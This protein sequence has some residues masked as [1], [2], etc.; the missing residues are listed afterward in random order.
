[1]L[2][3]FTR[4]TDRLVL[5][6]LPEII[7]TPFSPAVSSPARDMD[8]HSGIAM[9][10]GGILPPCTSATITPTSGGSDY[11]GQVLTMMENSTATS[12]SVIGPE[13]PP[14]RPGALPGG[15]FCP[16]GNPSG[17]PLGFM[18]NMPWMKTFAHGG[19]PDAIKAG[20]GSKWTWEKRVRFM[21]FRSIMPTRSSTRCPIRMP[22]GARIWVSRVLLSKGLS[23][24][25]GCWKAAWMDKPIL[26]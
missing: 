9:G 24:S 14:M 1:M 22:S 5:S 7:P 11:G 13:L 18:R 4:E 17:Y 26:P 6:A 8:P 2:M 15:C 10:I 23:V 20:N 3:A 25:G 19:V 12:V 16:M 21:P